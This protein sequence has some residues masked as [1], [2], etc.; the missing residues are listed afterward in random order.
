MPFATI[1]GASLYYE[2]VGTGTPILFAH[3]GIADS[4]MWDTQ[5][6][7]FKDDYRVIRLDF[8]GFGQSQP[9]DVPY[10]HREDIVGL[11]DHLGIEKAVIVGCSMNGKNAID[12]TLDQP[13]RVLALVVVGARPN[14]FT[15]DVLASPY[16]DDLETAEEAHDLVRI[17]ELE[18]LKWVAGNGRTRANVDPV[19]WALAQDMNRIA[20]ENEGHGEEK[21]PL[22]PPA[23][24]RLGEIQ[25]PVL[26]ICGDC[27]LPLM[28]SAADFMEQQIKGARKL[29]LRNA[30]HL[31]NMERPEEFNQALRAFLSEVHK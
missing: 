6:A 24:N 8:R 4:R 17:N 3:A 9:V 22:E 2:D 31:P 25:V 5:F 30:G 1:N 21:P 10:S 12:L 27:D 18:L 28:V 19:V 20:L 13:Q 11:L 26:I 23:V 7:A 29:I 15:S 16:E 14:G